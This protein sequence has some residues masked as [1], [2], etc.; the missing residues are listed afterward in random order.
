LAR[1]LAAKALLF[2]LPGLSANGSGDS[3][4][5]PI[6]NARDI[7]KK[8]PFHFEYAQGRS[9]PNQRVRKIVLQLRNRGGQAAEFH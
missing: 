2:V 7:H 9:L 8:A 6:M 4:T 1:P 3:K 5:W